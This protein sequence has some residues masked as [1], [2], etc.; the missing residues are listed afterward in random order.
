MIRKFPIVYKLTLV[1][2]LLIFLATFPVAWVVSKNLSKDLKSQAL[3]ETLARSVTRAKEIEET[4]GSLV[5]KT[6]NLGTLLL[7][8]HVSEDHSRYDKSSEKS[9]NLQFELDRDLTSLSV[10]ELGAG[11]VKELAKKEREENLKSLGLEKGYS[12]Y[13]EKRRPFARGKVFSGSIHLQNRS[14]QGKAAIL[15][16]GIPLFKDKLERVTHIAVADVK[17]QGIQKGFTKVDGNPQEA[18]RD[19]F[20]VDQEGKVLAHSDEK[21]VFKQNSYKRKSIVRRGLK[22]AQA[23]GQKRYPDKKRRQWMIG[24]Y[25]RTSYG[26]VVISEAPEH[27]ILEP[28]RAIERNIFLAAFTMLSISIFVITLFSTTLTSPIERLVRLAGEIARGNF[29]IH[30]TRAVRSRDEV[31]EL[32]FAF[33]HMAHG[34]RERDK[35]KNLLNKFHGSTIAEDLMQGEVATRG[36]RKDVA[37]FFSD[38]RGFT[39]FSESRTPEEVVNMLNEY[40]AVMVS[41]IAKSGGVVDK[42]IGDA[43]MAI[44]GA[45]KSTGDDAYA[46]VKA[47]L[48]MRMALEVLNEKRM[49]R[50]EVPIMI[51]MGVHFGSAI[52]GTIGSEDRLEYTVIGDSVNM[53]A[54]IEASTKSFGTDLLISEELSKL[55]E[56]RFVLEL[57][58]TVEVK[59]KSEGLKLFTCKG[60]IDENGD[61]I[62]LETPYSSYEKG[63]DAKVKVTS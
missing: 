27:L 10:Y 38:I 20:L 3:D 54:R 42:F 44:W 35:V 8:H 12:Q 32:A 53:A 29:N 16:I 14:I 17:I 41:I 39:A 49:A 24:A 37:V 15:S 21:L 30:A 23:F 56:T 50:G 40:F 19:T 31:G 61:E 26:L 55:V 60:Y 1:T 43:I 9:F 48:D 11:G 2:G 6:R 47:C 34:L 33:D 51:G 58:G 25:A 18:I 36:T 22:S 4:L 28:A 52:S 13:L 59:G 7:M 57:G 46:C 5:D 45:P 63:K 62:I